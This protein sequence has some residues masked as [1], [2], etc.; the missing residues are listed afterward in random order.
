MSTETTSVSN[1]SIFAETVGVDV[2]A[3]PLSVRQFPV[4]PPCVYFLIKGLSVVYVGQT[5]SLS[6]R[7]Y[8]HQYGDSSTEVK[9]FDSVRYFEVMSGDLDVVEAR[10]ILLFEPLYNKQL[11]GKSGLRRL[12]NLAGDQWL[13]FRECLT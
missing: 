2:E 12:K 3:S 1:I 5:R 4:I 8:S 13:K 6:G 11:R 7:V 9:D 10:Y